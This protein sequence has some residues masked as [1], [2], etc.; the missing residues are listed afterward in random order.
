[1]SDIKVHDKKVCEVFHNSIEVIG[2]RWNGAI[3]YAL[4]SGPKRFSEFTESIPDISSRLLTE[5]LKEL[6][7]FNLVNREVVSDRPIQVIYSLTQ[8]GQALQPI[9]ESI[10]NW[11]TQWQSSPPEE[12]ICIEKQA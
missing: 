12:I 3:I 4:F 5:R 9:M 8:K 2:R 10:G 1:M 6:E 7:E 11:A